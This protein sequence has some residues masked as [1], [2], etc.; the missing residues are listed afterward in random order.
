LALLTLTSLCAATSRSAESGPPTWSAQAAAKYLDARGEWWLG[1]SSSARGQGTSCISCH[2]A[3]P[4]ALARPALGKAL[5]ETEPGAVEKKLIDNVKK[6]VA[7]WEKIVAAPGQDKDPFVPFYPAS[8]KP[9][10]LGTEA[11]LNALILVNHDARWSKGTLAEPTRQ[12]LSILWSQQKPNGAW[13]WLDFGLR[14]WEKEG[15]YFGAALAAVAVGTADE[16]YYDQGTAKANTKALKDYLR[17]EFPKATLHD[18]VA[19]LWA[20]SV[21]PGILAEPEKNKLK[22]ELFALQE[23]DGGWSLPK[24]G[25][26]SAGKDSWKAYKVLPQGTTADG[27]ATGFVVLALKRSGVGADQPNLKKAIAWLNA[28]QKDGTWPVNF[29]NRDRDPQNDVGKFMRDAGAGFASL[30]LLEQK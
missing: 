17:S 8:K 30:A 24:L 2:S 4:V 26:K 18:R 20:A 13:L 3:L 14:P 23:A 22:D 1:W 9:S 27:Y 6:R 19:A 12:A 5:G 11:V 25:T 28:R 10:A 15:A 16:A 21:L 7:N 29:V